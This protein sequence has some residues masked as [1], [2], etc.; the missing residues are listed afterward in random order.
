MRE[1]VG[2]QAA[3]HRR[4]E[5]VKARAVVRATKGKAVVAVRAKRAAIGSQRVLVSNAAATDT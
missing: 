5:Q 3:A 1:I 4:R 2:Q